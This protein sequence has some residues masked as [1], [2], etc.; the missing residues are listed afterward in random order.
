MHHRHHGL[1]ICEVEQEEREFPVCADYEPDLHCL[2]WGGFSIAGSPDCESIVR[3]CY[4][5][6]F[7]SA[8]VALDEEDIEINKER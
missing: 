3:W 2:W 7:G 4:V 5:C 8:F 1:R 6:H